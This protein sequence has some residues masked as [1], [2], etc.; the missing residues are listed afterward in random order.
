[1]PTIAL[2]TTGLD[3]PP[4][5]GMAALAARFGA[6][7]HVVLP[8]FLDP[9]LLAVVR[10]KMVAETFVAR[11]HGSI[12]IE[13]CLPPGPTSGLLELVA[14]DPVLLDAVAALAGCGPLGCFE[15]RVYRMSPAAGHFDSW[16]GDVGQDRQVAMSV[17][18]GDPFEGGVL[19]LA[20][21]GDDAVLAAVRN[22]GP[23]DA[24]LFRI[25]P[26]LRHRVGAV[27]GAAP[28]TAYAGWFRSAPR[29]RDL[30]AARAGMS[31]PRARTAGPSATA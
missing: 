24:V 23:G 1:M 9:A 27:A 2:S 20:R 12:G 22:T 10:A 28:R 17:N 3:L 31:P 5:A 30:W 16:H 14:N 7:H 29:Y 21:T 18:L 26:W 4:P 15:G 13:E 8:G 11:R 19:E 25:A 6:A